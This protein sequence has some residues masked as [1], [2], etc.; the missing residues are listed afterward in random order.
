MIRTA[1]KWPENVFL[2][3]GSH[4]AAAPLYAHLTDRQTSQYVWA[5]AVVT[6]GDVGGPL[7]SQCSVPETGRSMRPGPR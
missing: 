2:L 1:I 3:C 4:L 7:D 6:A 5:T